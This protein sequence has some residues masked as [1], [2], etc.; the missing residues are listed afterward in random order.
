M[1]II[2]STLLTVLALSGCGTTRPERCDGSNRKPINTGHSMTIGGAESASPFNK[3]A[4]M[5]LFLERG[6]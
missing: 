5:A 2:V 1:R 4:G 3:S 6:Q